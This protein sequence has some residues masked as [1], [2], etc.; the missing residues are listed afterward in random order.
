MKPRSQ[1]ARVLLTYLTHFSRVRRVV[2]MD[3]ASILRHDQFVT[4][5]G[6]AVYAQRGYFSPLWYHTPARVSFA[7]VQERYGCNYLRAMCMPLGAFC[8]LVDALRPRLSRLG[9]PPDVRTAI[10]LR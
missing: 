8:D 10:A 6:G 1:P 4:T 2:A 7:D 3:P 5:V 9:V